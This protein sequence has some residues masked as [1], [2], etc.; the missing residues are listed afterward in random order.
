M[1]F[2]SYKKFCI[3]DSFEFSSC[4]VV[5]VSLIRKT[6]RKTACSTFWNCSLSCLGCRVLFWFFRCYIWDGCD[7]WFWFPL[8]IDG[9]VLY[10][11]FLSWSLVALSRK[12]TRSSFV[13]LVPVIVL[14][15]STT[16]RGAVKKLG[17]PDQTLKFSFKHLK[18]LYTLYT[19][20]NV[21]TLKKTTAWLFFWK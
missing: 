13:T 17:V 14:S 8:F 1:F 20:A 11:D 2:A 18:Q 10:K 12:Q 6:V 19:Y 15:A 16:S 21:R 7:L 9:R 4:N 5:V 3:W